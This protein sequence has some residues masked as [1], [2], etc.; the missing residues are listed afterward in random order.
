MRVAIPHNMGLSFR[1]RGFRNGRG[2]ELPGDQVTR[3]PP[4]ATISRNIRIAK[5]SSLTC[6]LLVSAGRIRGGLSGA[7]SL[8]WRVEGSVTHVPA[9]KPG[10]GPRP[11]AIRC[12]TGVP[13]SGACGTVAELNYPQPDRAAQRL[14]TTKKLIRLAE[15]NRCALAEAKTDGSAGAT[16]SV[17]RRDDLCRSGSWAP[18][19]RRQDQRRPEW[20]VQPCL[21]GRRLGDTCPRAQARRRSVAGENYAHRPQSYSKE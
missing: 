15:L 7:F 21:A 8:A 2:N 9:H 3:N 19:E 14:D 16:A 1:A 6:G 11:P 13:P 10:D 4:R 18:R 12:A 5:S 20:G 17:N